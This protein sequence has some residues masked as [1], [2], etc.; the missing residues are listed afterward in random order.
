M[1]TALRAG[2]SQGL[3]EPAFLEIFDTTVNPEAR[4]LSPFTWLNLLEAEGACYLGVVNNLRVQGPL[5]GHF[6]AVRE[7]G[8]PHRAL[9]RFHAALGSV[10]YDLLRH[11]PVALSDVVDA[12]S[13]VAL[14]L[15][16]GGARLLVLLPA[17]IGRL[18]LQAQ[19]EAAQWGDHRGRQVAVHATLLDVQDRIVPGLIPATLTWRHP[20]GSRSDFS[21]HTVFRRGVLD[22]A[23]PVLAN[24]PT[25]SWQVHVLERASGR[26]AEVGV[27]VR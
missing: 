26:S 7:T 1:A 12:A 5:Y 21:H 11:E 25:G 17:P 14:D 6:G 3:A 22:C 23:L 15:P 4:T 19:V 27:S 10:A 24:G 20:D 9:V 8:V 13:T 2:G 18:E 16:P